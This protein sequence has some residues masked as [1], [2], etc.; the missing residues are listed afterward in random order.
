MGKSIS[1]SKYSQELAFNYNEISYNQLTK[2]S[3]PSQKIEMRGLDAYR[4]IQPYISVRFMEQVK[5]LLPLVVYLVLFQLFI[6]HQTI[7]NTLSISGGMFAVVIGLMFFMEGIKQGLMPLGEMMGGTLP[8]KLA[9][10]WVLFIAFLLGVA[11]T[12]AEPAIGALKAAGSLVP[13]KNPDGSVADS[14]YLYAL[15]NIYTSTLVLLVGVGVGMAAVLGTIR[16]VKGWSLKPYIYLSLTPVIALTLY[17][18]ST[19]QLAAIL[20]LA[21]DSGAVTTGPVT[22]PLVLALGIGIAY[23]AGKGGG[24]LMGFGIVTLASLFPIMVVLILAIALYHNV[25]PDEI[26]AQIESLKVPAG[27]SVSWIDSSPGAEIVGGVRSILP[28]VLF[29]IIIMKLVLKSPISN[30]A[31]VAYGIFL[32]ILGM[33]IFNI[34]LTYGLSALGAQ[35]GSMIPSAFSDII[36]NGEEI[37]RL[38]PYVIGI[39]L[40][41]IFAWVLGFGAT[42]AEPALNA[43]GATVEDLTNGV[44]KKKAL[45]YSVSIGVGTGIALG[46][47]KIIFNIPLTYMLLPSYAFALILTYL[48]K[49]EFV[50]VAWDSAGVTTGPITVPLVL[51]MGLGVAGATGGLDGFGILTMASVGPIITVQMTGLYMGYKEKQ[52]Q[53]K[54]LEQTNKG[55]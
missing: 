26:L 31:R 8:K 32:A 51:A 15:L 40:T 7:A 18:M 14:I 9:L 47:I 12:F 1:F 22:V 55:I 21:W 27:Q 35:A 29:L 11:V 24:K 41:I 45:V 16:F 38:Y 42:L 34:G 33:C 10:Y 4:L 30:A 23:S 17:C 37:A 52:K 53:L 49:E 28:L 43:L 6:L 36:I 54:Q 39:L 5:S 50:N 3:K 13:Y 44:F 20:G 48:S 25:T 2:N 19:P 46:V